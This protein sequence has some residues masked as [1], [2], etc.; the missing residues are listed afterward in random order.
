VAIVVAG[1]ALLVGF[2]AVERRLGKQAMVPLNMFG[3]PSFVG[4]SLLTLLVY[5]VLGGLLIL[6]PYVLIR[7][8]GYSATLAGA[9]LLPFPVLMAVASP[10]MGGLA[11]RFGARLPLAAGS[12]VMGAGLLLTLNIA[13]GGGYWTQVMPPLVVVAVGMAGVAAPLT[14]AVL[15]SVDAEHAGSASG[16]NSALARTGGLI[17]TALL[18]AV[19]AGQG[20]A[21][22]AGFHAAAWVGAAS[23]AAAAVCALALI[24]DPS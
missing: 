7:S 14:T 12:L 15:A 20:T 11:G 13:A 16:L 4:L 1:L 17:A 2:I 6:L 18:G 21:L 22:I 3:S 19:L 23:C 5:G 24:R 8:G 9:A 10:L